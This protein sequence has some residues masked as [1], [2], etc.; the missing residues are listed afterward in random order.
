MSDAFFD[1]LLGYWLAVLFAYWALLFVGIRRFDSLQ[2]PASTTHAVLA[3]VVIPAFNER[4]HLPTIGANL[5][6]VR[7]TGTRACVVDDGSRDGSSGELIELCLGTGARLLR[8]SLNRGKAAA[9]RTGVESTAAP[10]VLLLDA[11][12]SLPA[13]W[14]DGVCLA[15]REAAVAC[16][17]VAVEA[18]FLASVQAREY[19]YVL[20]LEREALAGFG[21]VLTVPGAA[22]IWRTAALR[23]IGGFSARTEAEDTDATLCLQISGWSV[24]VRSDIVALTDCPGT[25]WSLVKQRGRWIWGNFQAAWY[26]VGASARGNANRRAA[27]AMAAVSLLNLLGY[28]IATVMVARLILLDV[29]VADVVAAGGLSLATIGRIVLTRRFR[30]V[31]NRS[32]RQ[33]LGA[34]LLMQLINFVSFWHGMGARL[35]RLQTWK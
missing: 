16:R 29:G 22:S 24:R 5:A 26:A 18:G 28:I 33:V 23:D 1:L 34:L 6:A 21:V 19:E 25:F 20:N 11:D 15:K 32:L 10:F 4:R 27:I 30:V 3:E 7:R 31:R 13:N 35:L 2:V 9:V 8:H 17:I 14:R 12:T